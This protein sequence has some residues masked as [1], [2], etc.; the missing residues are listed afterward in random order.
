MKC[1]SLR[2]KFSAALLKVFR[3][4]LTPKTTTVNI[5]NLDMTVSVFYST[6]ML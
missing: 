6:V 4:H 2:I 3:E 1:Y 5:C